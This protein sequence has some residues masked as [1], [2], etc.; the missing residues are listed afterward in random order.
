MSF[1]YNYFIQKN[2]QKIGYISCASFSELL[3]IIIDS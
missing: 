2:V 3:R 1:V